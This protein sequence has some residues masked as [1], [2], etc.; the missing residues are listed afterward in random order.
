MHVA[1][2]EA[3]AFTGQAARAQCRDTTF[4]R[5]FRQRI[6][7]VH[8][9]RQLTGAKEFL[10]RSRDRLRVDEILRHQAFALC[11][12][13]ALFDRALNAD[14]ANPELVFGHLAYRPDA[15]VTE[16]VDIVHHALAVADINQRADDVD[17]IFFV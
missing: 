11:H 2:L 9:L 6:V 17:D 14:K 4:V 3:G 13:E 7:L 5:D 12:R 16:V 1:H 10:H 15:A 8:E